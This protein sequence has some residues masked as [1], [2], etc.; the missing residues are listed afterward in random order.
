MAI[1]LTHL[2]TLYHDD[3]MDE[4]AMRRGAPSANSRWDN[5]VAILTGDFL[6]ARASQILA[7]LGPEAVRI[8]AET[9]ARLVTGQIAETV[10][11]RPGQD[12]VDHYLSVVADKTASLIA[13]SGRFGAMF[14]GAP[15][16]VVAGITPACERI[17]VAFQLSDDMLDVAS[18]SAQSGK[19]PGTDLREGVRTLPV[20][21]ALRRPAPATP[22]WWSC[23]LRRPDRPGAARRGARAAAR[24]PG[25]WRWPGARRAAAGRAGPGRDPR[26]A[27]GARPGRVRG[28]LRLRGRADRLIG[29][30]ACRS[31]RTS[32]ST[33]GRTANAARA[34]EPF[35]EAAVPE[36]EVPIQAPED[37]LAARNS[38]FVQSLDRGL[39]VIRAFGPDR[40]RLSLSEVARA[41]GLTRAAARRF[42][43]TLVKLGYVRS[44][45]REF[46]LRPEG[47][48][49]RLRLPVRAG[50]ARGGRAAHGGARG[51]A[52]RVLLDLGAGRRTTSSTSPACRP[53][54][55]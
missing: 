23:S 20:L 34:S 10:G 7:D 25:A 6:F 32:G 8:Q 37:G 15:A 33:P 30:L 11:P 50:A 38:D 18:E 42:L 4:A 44:D 36:A 47:A 2:A 53:S 43:L 31:M 12:P 17:G 35:P 13:T 26:P 21:H 19:T 28:A 46:S 24:A 39:A 45:G 55:S 52:A 29:A 14:S 16:S 3:V 51:E 9:F 5:T 41:T 48:R 40:E 27:R 54:G 1:E 49:A 22:G